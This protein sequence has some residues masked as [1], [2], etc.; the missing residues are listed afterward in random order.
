V[1]IFISEKYEIFPGKVV[2][3]YHLTDKINLKFKNFS[4]NVS[5]ISLERMSESG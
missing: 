2:A 3:S 4:A 1:K 5:G